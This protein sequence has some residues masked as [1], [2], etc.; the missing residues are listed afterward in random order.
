[1]CANV[2]LQGKLNIPLYPCHGTFS[3]KGNI[4]ASRNIYTEQKATIYAYDG[5]VNC[6]LRIRRIVHRI[7]LR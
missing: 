1:M 3:K 7:R 5:F 4:R 2:I 6:R